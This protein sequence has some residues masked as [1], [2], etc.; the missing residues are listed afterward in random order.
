MNIG[1]FT[2]LA[3]GVLIM[4]KWL[5]G[6]R[7]YSIDNVIRW[8][9]DIELAAAIAGVPANIIA[10]LVM[11]ESQGVPDAV[12]SAGELGLTQITIAAAVDVGLSEVPTDPY[13]N[14]EAGARYLKLQYDRMSQHNGYTSW[15]EALRAYN[16]GFSG[17]S[18]NPMRSVAYARTVFGWSVRLVEFDDAT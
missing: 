18:E 7:L 17:A 14:I 9:S 2:I 3:I 13:N 10:G 12:G 5:A 6:S 16:C 4:L 11:V 1:T 15:F 8:K